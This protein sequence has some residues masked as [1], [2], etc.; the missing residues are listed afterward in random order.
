[1]TEHPLNVEQ[2]EV[3]GTI[4]GCRPVQDP[5]GS[6][7]QVVRGDVAQAGGFGPVIDDTEKRSVA[8][9]V[10]PVQPS[11]STVA[12]STG[13]SAVMTAADPGS[14]VGSGSGHRTGRYRRSPCAA[15]GPC[16]SR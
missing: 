6:A 7:A 4:G 8:R 14:C 16:R 5:G 2:V 3:M 1:M 10:V 13:R 15:C 12:G 9:P 11:W